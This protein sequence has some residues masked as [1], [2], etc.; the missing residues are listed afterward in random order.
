MLTYFTN[1][2]QLINFELNRK[3]LDL[4]LQHIS[5]TDLTERVYDRSEVLA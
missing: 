5:Q 4:Y 3:F 1:A 2:K